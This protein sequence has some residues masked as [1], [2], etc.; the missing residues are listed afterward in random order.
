MPP[1][2]ARSAGVAG[3]VTPS[4]LPAPVSAHVFTRVTLPGT[5]TEMDYV[6]VDKDTA[7]VKAFPDL[8]WVDSTASAANTVAAPL[9]SIARVVGLPAFIEDPTTPASQTIMDLAEITM[10]CVIV[11]HNVGGR[12]FFRLRPLQRSPDDEFHTALRFCSSLA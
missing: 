7:V 12:P 5:E 4:S 10:Q 2:T 9:L 6:R 1:A 11:D 8:G 3:A